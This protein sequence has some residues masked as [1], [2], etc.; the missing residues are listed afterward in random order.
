VEEGFSASQGVVHLR[1]PFSTLDADRQI[2]IHYPKGALDEPAVSDGD[3]Q[4]GSAKGAWQNHI[5]GMNQ[6]FA[7]GE[8]EKALQ[9]TNAALR[10]A[11]AS[12]DPEDKRIVTSLLG[13]A[14]LLLQTGKIT[15]AVPFVAR[16]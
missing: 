4:P 3:Q 15:E 8:I 1:Q 6:L 7:R 11:D 5:K 12:F 14:S 13:L 9:E 10:L 2:K 16:A